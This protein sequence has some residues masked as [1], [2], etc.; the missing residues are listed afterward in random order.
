M[1]TASVVQSIGAYGSAVA[2]GVYLASSN[3]TRVTVMFVAISL[4][5]TLMARRDWRLA[6]GLLRSPGVTGEPSRPTPIRT[7]E[8]EQ[9]QTGRLPFYLSDADLF[10]RAS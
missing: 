3:G 6:A 8:V 1:K 2:I 9:G 10:S 7:Y 4:F 5:A